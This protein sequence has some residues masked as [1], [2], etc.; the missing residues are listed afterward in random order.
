VEAVPY[1]PL[2]L[3]FLI[4]DPKLADKVSH[5]LK[6]IESPI[7]YHM[8]GQSLDSGDMMDLLGFGSITR[9]I[10]IGLTTQAH[11]DKILSKLEKKLRFGIYN[12]GIAFTTAI[13]SVSATAMKI[14][15]GCAK[16]ELVKKM[17]TDTKQ[18]AKNSD[19]S[20]IIS[21]INQGYSE[22]V[23]D[24]AREVGAP[25]GTVL[26]ARQM[27]GEAAL[28]F[29]GLPLQEERDLV[30]II[31]KREEKVA[32]MKSIG[33]K[34]GIHSKARGISMSTPIDCCVGIEEEDDD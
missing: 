19:Y 2:R 7:L 3:L 25:I 31:A 10:S 26:H 21:I 8:R 22:D 23:M 27:G 9:I 14:A 15:D 13:S 5:L 30:F 1:K 34:C 18:V 33:E 29:L 17:E 24:A 11:A 4:T 16:E 32:I 6:H 28:N 20:L 12:D